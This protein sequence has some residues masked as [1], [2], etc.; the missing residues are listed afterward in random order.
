MCVRDK[1]TLVVGVEPVH[2]V[3]LRACGLINATKVQYNCR[4][5]EAVSF[6]VDTELP[7]LNYGLNR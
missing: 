3:S 7:G 4:R 2:V 6:C 1:F 5:H